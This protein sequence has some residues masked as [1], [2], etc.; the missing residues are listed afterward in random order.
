LNEPRILLYAPNVHTGGGAVL[1]EAL[2][3]G[4]PS[5]VPVLAW[6][7]QRSRDRGAPLPEHVQVRWVAA[8]AKS[9]WSAEWNLRREARATDRLLCF[10]GLPPLW[11]SRAFTA[12]FQQNRNLLGQVPL[13]QFAPRTR[14]RL[15]FEQQ[16]SRRMRRHVDV[17]WV[18]TEAMADA[19]RAWWGPS[20]TPTVRVCG[21]APPLPLH[22]APSSTA[23]RRDFIYVA[24][25]EAHKNHR[26]LL[27]AWVLLADAGHRPSLALTLGARDRA[28]RAEWEAGIAA[29]GLAVEF[30]PPMDHA[31]VLK[32]Y[33]ESGALVFPSLGESYGL[34]LVEAAAQGLPIVA[35]ER[36][37]VREVCVPVQTFD[38][39]SPR[40]IAH[41]VLR[42]LQLAPAPA[43]P[44]SAADFWRACWS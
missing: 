13:R 18:Q 24:D 35:A 5:G 22:A 36:D 28:L 15:W 9:R 42:H 2:L 44:A 34:P 6:L 30:L 41:A 19:V 25:G 37:Y 31:A 38:P 11:R 43:A 12:L 16:V 23:P 21:F 8:T 10:H 4:L 17:Y 29:Y 20:G 32:A 1:L 3:R 39:E 33:A 14:V 7:D 27:A 40:S 26:R